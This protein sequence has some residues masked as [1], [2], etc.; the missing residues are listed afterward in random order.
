MT[1]TYLISWAPL[2]AM[3]SMFKPLYSSPSHAMPENTGSGGSYTSQPC[4]LSLP[5]PLP[6]VEATI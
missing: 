5:P 6:K 3:F 4:P 1:P 2:R